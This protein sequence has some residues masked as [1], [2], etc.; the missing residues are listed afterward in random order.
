MSDHKPFDECYKDVGSVFR[1]IVVLTDNWVDDGDAR[2]QELSPVATGRVMV[3]HDLVAIDCWDDLTT[4]DIGL[5]LTE[6]FD[7]YE[8]LSDC[9]S[10]ARLRAIVL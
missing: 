4:R 7:R 2:R 8:Y 6:R 10:I 1:E 5:S 3:L 9:D